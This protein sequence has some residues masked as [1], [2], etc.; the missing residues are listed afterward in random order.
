[1]QSITYF[2]QQTKKISTE[3][4][5][6]VTRLEQVVFYILLQF[7]FLFLREEDILELDFVCYSY[8][9]FV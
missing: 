2:R 4:L 3:L 7:S 9:L 5:T 6:L 1:M 8:S